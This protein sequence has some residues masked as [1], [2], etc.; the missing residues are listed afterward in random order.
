MTFLTDFGSQSSYPAQMKAIALNLTNST[1]IDITHDIQSHNIREGA[2][3][4][5]TSAPYFP[6]GTI[7][8]AVVD[9]GVGTTRRSI[10]ITTK[11]QIFVGP[12]NGLLIPAADQC[13]IMHVYEITNE[14][15]FLHPRSATFDG[16]DVFTPIAA[17]ILNG[18]P[19][20][21]FGTSITDYIPLSFG[22]GKKTG[23]V[24]E[25]EIV[26][27]DRFGNAITNIEKNVLPDINDKKL[28]TLKV[29]ESSIN[30]PFVKTYGQVKL[31]ELL[32]TVGSSNFVEISMN[33]G[34]AAKKLKLKETMPVSIS[35]T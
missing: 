20:E 15:Y 10:V 12:D 30:I 2:F 18:T 23:N 27:I 19:F 16:R 29:S 9:P 5:K 11:T 13:N 4:L 33:Q 35:I 6:P 25:G 3:I 26:Y 34:N 21:E 8:V 7:H 14:K 24:I 31:K 1:L 28:L 17:H 32:L 22:I